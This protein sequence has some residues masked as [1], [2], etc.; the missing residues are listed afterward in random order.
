MFKCAIPGHQKQMTN[1]STNC[2]ILSCF[3]FK[4]NDGIIDNDEFMSLKEHFE[5]LPSEGNEEDILSHYCKHSKDKKVTEFFE[6]KYNIKDLAFEFCEKEND[7]SLLTLKIRAII[8]AQNLGEPF[9]SC[10]G[11]TP[12]FVAAKKG[13]LECVDFLLNCQNCDLTTYWTLTG[14][15]AL[16]A[17]SSEGHLD[18]VSRLLEGGFGI[19][20]IDNKLRT[21]LHFACLE[22]HTAVV[23][24]LLNRGCQID[25]QS[26][27]GDTALHMAAMKGH[28]DCCKLL[29]K[30]GCKKDVLNEEG[31]TAITNSVIYEKIESAHVLLDKGGAC[32]AGA[33]CMLDFEG[34]PLSPLYVATQKGYVEFVKLLIANGADLECMDENGETPLFIA[35]FKGNLEIVKLLLDAGAQKDSQSYAGF[36]PFYL[37]CSEGNYGV[38]KLLLDAG[39]NINFQMKDGSNSLFVA[40]GKGYVSIVKMLLDAGVNVDVQIKNQTPLWFNCFFGHTECAR[41]LIEAGCN[42]DLPDNQGRNPLL[43]SILTNHFEIVKL[44]LKA[45]CERNALSDEGQSALCA[46]VE[47]GNIDC[48]KLLIQ[49][50]CLL[51]QEGQSSSPLYDASKIGNA[52][53]V[54]LFLDHGGDQDFKDEQGLTP[55]LV[56]QEKNHH[57]IVA[58]FKEYK[59]Q[60]E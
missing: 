2:S 60:K 13:D 50:G 20:S 19:D 57:D 28:S 37:A 51:D 52:D 41:L 22:G 4:L 16:H 25:L 27:A 39:C 45:G 53:F 14:E 35:T 33:A 6:K 26:T 30:A 17:A 3:S 5:A 15:N 55:F 36:T 44:L 29:L 31:Y 24:F 18:C 10:D 11:L 34:Q 40:S 23:E 42:V 54:K 58:L 47:A 12:I 43:C 32:D 1:S 49:E 38:A 7:F 46:S 9:S 8:L 21:P 56:A 59:C 48:A